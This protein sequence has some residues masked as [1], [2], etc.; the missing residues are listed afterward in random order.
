MCLILACPMCLIVACVVC[1]LLACVVCSV[2]ACLVC[3]VLES[4]F[5]VVLEPR[6]RFASPPLSV[7]IALWAVGPYGTQDFESNYMYILFIF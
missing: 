4:V 3:V 7:G 5:C 1:L 6:A 2:I